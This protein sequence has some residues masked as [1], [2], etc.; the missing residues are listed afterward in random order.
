M[1]CVGFPTPFIAIHL[2]WINLITDSLPAIA[3]GMDPKE[4]GI[5]DEKPRKANE[6]LFARGGLKN[7]ILYGA[8]I[9]VS[10]IL[11]YL[12]NAWMNGQFTYS[13]INTFYSNASNLHLAQTMAFTALAFSELLNMLCMS[14]TERSFIHI[15]KSKNWMI[16]IAMLLGVGLQLF[17]I[18][19]PGVSDVF[20]TANMDWAHWLI[21]LAC[22]F[23]PLVYHEIYVCVKWIIKKVK[24]AQ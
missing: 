9:T 5:M 13:A 12:S 16:L 4:P 24:K 17:V 22:A 11:A 1:I 20:S 2:L 21:T 15:F 18:E 8:I 14:N 10:V 19:T 7:T 3:L 6:S 23:A